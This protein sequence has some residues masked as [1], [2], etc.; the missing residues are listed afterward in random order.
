MSWSL[1]R[2]AAGAL[3]ILLLG[4][5]G[6]KDIDKRFFVV[7]T[8]IDSSGNP[9]K[10]FRITLKL[11]VTSPKIEPGAGKSQ[12]ETIEARTIAEGV[13][14]LKAYVDKELDF[15]HCK[16]FMIGEPLARQGIRPALNWMT[17]RRDI[18]M[19][20][21]V[22]IGVPSAE[23]IL[24][25]EPKTERYPGNTLFL[26]FGHEGTESSYTFTQLVFELRRRMTEKGF[27]PILPIVA[28]EK[29][30]Y[31][32]NQL[33]VMNKQKLLTIL[34]PEETQLLNQI[35]NTFLKS[36]V[37]GNVEED[38]YVLTVGRI[39]STYKVNKNDQGK[40]V[41]T[42]NINITGL[43]EEAPKM[44]FDKDWNAIEQKMASQ[45]NEA[46]KKLLVKFQKLG[47]DPIGF[48]LRYRAT[49]YSKDDT[50]WKEWLS[51]YPEAEFQINTKIT[52]EGTG[53]IK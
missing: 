4:G 31:R 45:Y 14:E 41:I 11:A 1:I 52:V 9:D 33:G 48:G 8:G 21:N 24:L 53:L 28:A 34:Q 38:P 19:I 39:K 13:R 27:D 10:P 42:M 22:S 49:H 32:I 20:S 16:I 26:S 35:T 43:L 18:Q 15:G 5:C 17:R 23:S 47:I 2:L 29:D 36:S 51:L 7:A 6:F 12:M 37:G 46:V 3:I 50:N 44:V 30:S 25:I 40:L